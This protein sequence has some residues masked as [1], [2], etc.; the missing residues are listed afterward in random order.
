MALKHQKSNE[1]TSNG[2]RYYKTAINHL[3]QTRTA[4][5]TPKWF[6][7]WVNNKCNISIGNPLINLSCILNFFGFNLRVWYIEQTLTAFRP[8]YV[9]VFLCYVGALCEE[10]YTATI[11]IHSVLTRKIRKA[12]ITYML[13][14]HSIFHFV[15]IVDYSVQREYI[16]K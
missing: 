2:V 14:A 3:S 5:R 1:I 15:P 9:Y 6:T 10:E 4:K 11:F 13:S 8:V 7:D 12:N 16:Q